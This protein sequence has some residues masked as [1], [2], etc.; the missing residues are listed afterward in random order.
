[1]KSYRNCSIITQ[2]NIKYIQYHFMPNNK[3][4]P[5]K[6]P[7]P[8]FLGQIFFSLTTKVYATM[9]VLQFSGDFP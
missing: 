7:S 3:L 4:L 2:E 1:M 6:S 5:N 8:H 9:T